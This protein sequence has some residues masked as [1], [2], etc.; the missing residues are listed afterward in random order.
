MIENINRD[1][2]DWVDTLKIDENIPI[3]KFSNTCSGS[4]FSSCFALFIKNLIDK[5]SLIK[6]KDAWV[7]YIQSFQDEA[8]GLFKPDEYY[9][10]DKERTEFQLTCFCIS[11]LNILDANPL[12]PLNFIDERWENK[13]D[14]FN[15]LKLKGCH[16]GDS[17]SGNSAMFLGI[18]LT[19]QFKKTNE[20]KYKDL[21][22]H[23]F[24]FHNQ[25]QNKSTGAWGFRKA[26]YYHHGLQNG[27]H[28]FIIYNYW[29]KKLPNI[30]ESIEIALKIQNFDGSF[31]PDPGGEG[32]HDYDL[33]YFLCYVL[34][35]KI[36]QDKHNQIR[37]MLKKLKKSIMSNYI[38][39]NGFAQS[40]NRVLTFSDFF[41]QLFLIYSFDF[42]LWY[43]RLKSMSYVYLK[44]KKSNQTAWSKDPRL[45]REANLW[46]TWFRLQTIALIEIS[47]NNN[48]LKKYGFHDHIGIGQYVGMK[49]EEY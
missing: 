22:N 41:R 20:K 26:D 40:K 16:R 48:V 38:D 18:F 13:D 36:A 23:W 27:F 44:N 10:E 6:D 7:H 39:K 12:H 1:I 2:L 29:D 17:G 15:Y 11:A 5:K 46:D 49:R 37:I 31:S 4:I 32:C 3:Y 35:N 19:F 21:I 34:H 33:A 28:Q 42:K 30:E 9:I 24:D 25:Y 45:V 43:I 14:L 47:E 8:S